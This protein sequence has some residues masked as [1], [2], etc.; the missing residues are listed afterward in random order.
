M[1]SAFSSTRTSITASFAMFASFSGPT[2]PSGKTVTTLPTSSADAFTG[3]PSSRTKRSPRFQLV[4]PSRP[5]GFG[6]KLRIGNSAAMP[7]TPAVA[8]AKRTSHARRPTISGAAFDQQRGRIG[9]LRRRVDE[10]KMFV[11]DAPR[12]NQR[13][14]PDDE[15]RREREACAAEPDAFQLRLTAAHERGREQHAAGHRGDEPACGPSFAAP[16]ARRAHRT[17]QSIA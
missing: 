8:H 2:A 9:A 6:P 15:R 1:R 11:L 3:E 17:N 14:A 7:S 13:A 12:W 5:F 4:S 10:R 16:F